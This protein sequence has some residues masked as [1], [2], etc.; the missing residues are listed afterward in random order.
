[1]EI[2]GSSFW[3]INLLVQE[4]LI[5]AVENMDADEVRILGGLTSFAQR[6]EGNAGGYGGQVWYRKPGTITDIYIY[7]HN[8]YIYI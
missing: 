1:M 7:I 3:L 8:I 2:E 4:K 5:E 6:R